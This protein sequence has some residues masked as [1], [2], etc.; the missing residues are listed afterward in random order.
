MTRMT[1]PDCAVMCNLIKNIHTYI[2]IQRYFAEYP[3]DQAGKAASPARGLLNRENQYFP[4][5][6]R[7]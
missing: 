2:Y 4:V 5:P 3:V 6:V 1:E 7:A